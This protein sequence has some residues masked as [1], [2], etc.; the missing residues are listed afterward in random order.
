M[1]CPYCG[2]SHDDE[3]VVTSIEHAIP[4]GL[5]G[6]D[7]LTI[8]T[9][10]LSNNTLGSNVDAPFMDFFPVRSKRFF[11]GLESAK[12]HK[13]TLDLGGAGWIDGKEVPI[14][15]LISGDSKELKVEDPKVVRTPM[16]DGSELWQVSGDPAKVR[17]IVE[18]RL[19][20]QMK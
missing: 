7:D 6:S 9:C 11:L 12:G 10:D 15:Y 2:T 8:I 4:Y 13:P 5:G 3:T 17:E 16:P 18:G 20:K 14:S 1:Y 19:R